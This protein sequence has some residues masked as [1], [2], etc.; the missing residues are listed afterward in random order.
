MEIDKLKE[1]SQLYVEYQT[2]NLKERSLEG[3]FKD[4]QSGKL[5]REE[6]IDIIKGDDE[7][8]PDSSL[9]DYLEER[10]AK[11]FVKWQNKKEKAQEKIEQM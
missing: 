10:L 3:L 8:F 6:M 2:A 1:L 5:T 4:S 7:T 11:N 9:Q